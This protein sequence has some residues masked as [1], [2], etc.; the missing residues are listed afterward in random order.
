MID[1]NIQS[2]LVVAKFNAMPAKVHAALVTKTGVLRLMLESKAKEKVSGQVLNVR[3][4]RLRRAIF[5][6]TIDRTNEIIGRAA[7]SSDVPYAAIHEYGGKTPAHDIVP[8]GA[9]ALAFMAGGKMRFAKIVH[10]PG[11]TMPERSFMRSSLRELTPDIISGLKEAAM[12][13]T[14]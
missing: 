7:V 6:Q 13:A 9:K 8:V 4:G 3:T 14:K 10:H 11:S 12:A 1:I 5:S 2:E